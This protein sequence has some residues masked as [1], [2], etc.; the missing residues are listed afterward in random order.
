M[1][2]SNYSAFRG[3]R[4]AEP[5][6]HSLYLLFSYLKRLLLLYKNSIF[7]QRIYEIPGKEGSPISRIVYIGN[8]ENLD[9][10]EDSMLAG[11]ALR[12]ERKISLVECRAE[13]R[14]WLAEKAMVVVD[15]N[16]FLTPFLP[17]GGH[18]SYPWIRQV[19]YLDSIE[20]KSRRRN[21]MAEFRRIMRQQGYSTWM[22]SDPEDV[23]FFYEKLY[24]PF[25]HYRFGNSARPR[26]LSELQKAVKNGFITQVFHQEEWVA[27]EI[28]RICRNEIQALSSGLLPD[29]LQFSR[30]KARSAL[31]PILFEWASAKGYRKINLLRSRANLTDGVFSSKAHRGATAEIDSWPHSSLQIYIPA[32][33]EPPRI[34]KTQLVKKMGKPVPLGDVLEKEGTS[35]HRN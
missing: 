8:K 33:L 9:W 23:I 6:N 18:T 17:S 10:L 28:F 25:V 29:Y 32:G 19:V 16:R 14:R 35:P 4:L 13:I 5:A 12:K 30:R 1:A 21:I 3:F 26:K 11:E 15:L 34:W 24:R 27:G 22:T 2:Y 31:Y 7:Y 20:Y